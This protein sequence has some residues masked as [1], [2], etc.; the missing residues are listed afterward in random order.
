MTHIQQ[1]FEVQELEMGPKAGTP[2]AQQS[3]ETLRK[4]I[5]EQILAHYDRLRARDKKGVALVRHGVCTGCQMRLASGV[6]AMLFR[7]DDIGLC[8]SCGRYLLLAPEELPGTAAPPS[9]PNPPPPK[10][11]RRKAP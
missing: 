9:D 8:D 6:H 2:E 1:L 11:R 7:A 3:I 4:S 10:K 5:P